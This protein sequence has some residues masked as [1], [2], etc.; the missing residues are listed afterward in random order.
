MS[1]IGEL[2]VRLGL[3]SKGLT[4]GLAMA[5]AEARKFGSGGLGG[6]SSGMAKAESA[7]LKEAGAVE[8]GG[9][10]AA[11]AAA[12]HA[13]LGKALGGVASLSGLTPMGEGISRLN[14]LNTAAEAA[15]GG[16]LAMGAVAGGVLVAGVAAAGFA[17]AGTAKKFDDAMVLIQTQ[18]GASA[19]EVETMKGAVLGM[20]G[21]VGQ[22]PEALAQ[23][24]FHVESAGFRG[25][26]A[27]EVL[28]TAA[29]GAA[30]G[31]VD[32]TSVTN[33]LTAAMNSGVGGVQ[34]ASQ[35][36]GVLNAV[37]GAGNMTMEDLTAA[38]GTG[39]LSTAK[40]FGVSIQSVGGAIAAMANQG[41][42]AVDAATRLSSAMR[43][44]AAPTAAAVKDLKSIGLSSTQLASDMR[45]PGGMMS[46][47]QDLKTHMDKAGL[48]ATKQAALLSSAFGGKQSGGILTLVGGLDKLKTATDAV[49]KG[50]TGFGDAWAT[51]QADIDQRQKQLGASFDAITVK[52]GQ[53]FVPLEEAALPVIQKVV[54]GIGAVIDAVS[55]WVAA[56][57]PLISQVTG[58]IGTALSP[59]G[60][61]MDFL[62]SHIEIVAGIVGGLLVAALVAVGAALAPVVVAVVAAAA[63]FIAIGAAIGAVVYVV[64]HWTEV[65]Q[66]L[67]PIFS[68]VM[69]AIGSAIG[70][71]GNFI[72]SVVGNII[73]FFAAIPGKVADFIGQ[74]VD[75]FLSIPQRIAE[76]EIRVARMVVQ[77]AAKFVATVRDFVARAVAFVLSIPGRIVDFATRVLEIA[78]DLDRRFIGWIGDMVGKAVD[79]VLSI[80]GKIAGLVGA[81][82]DVARQAVAAFMGFVGN[83]PGQVAGVLH[84]IPGLG[85]LMDL[86]GSA[87]GAVAGAIPH[88]AAGSPA[89]P[90]DML[91]FLHAGEMVVPAGPAAS[92]RAASTSGAG[93]PA[94]AAAAGGT[95]S[96]VIN[97]VVNNP[98]A[99]PA[100]TSLRREIDKMQ[101]L[102]GFGY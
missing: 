75:F 83:I 71:V 27:E 12:K 78:A 70:A 6:L 10:K 96:Q 26:K 94:R 61:V 48:S 91:A 100:S 29:Q 7:A 82:G 77:L 79:F 41:I 2:L 89:I 57:Q 21:Q 25:A 102:A 37:V 20:A 1:V 72:G 23:A 33:A 55:G 62:S 59:L 74:V 13:N 39:V 99:E 80:P 85:N 84:G 31:H 95:H 14:G 51:T 32:L 43:L 52:F 50:A 44:M 42:P 9:V 98:A 38:M 17:A 66:A 53:L 81:F 68:A 45:S 97:L 76:F 11:E 73:G 93:S 34:D 30:V 60:A 54:D 88:F 35:A 58:L 65:T 87:V 63:P 101:R 5:E 69:G 3:D 92:I 36:M 90:R 49:G 16:M 4:G 15:G 56:N 28:R 47:I 67:G 18:A 46:A 24:L 22:A 8:K 40:N 19:A 64:T 86:G